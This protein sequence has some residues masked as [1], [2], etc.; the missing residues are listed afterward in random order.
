MPS[1][2]TPSRSSRKIVTTRRISSSAGFSAAAP[3]PCQAARRAL[4]DLDFL[5][6][7]VRHGQD[8]GVEAAQERA[9]QLVDALIAVIRRGDHV[10][11]L[12]RLHLGIQ[13][14][15][16]QR[17]LGKDRDERVLNV[18]GNARQLLDAGDLAVLHRAHQRAERPA[19]QPMGPWPA[20]ARSSSRSGSPPRRCRQCPAPAAW[21][22]RRSPPTRCSLNQ[23][24]AVPG[25][26]RAAERG[27]WR[28][29][30]RRSRSAARCRCTW[31]K[32]RSHCR[33]CHRG[34]KSNGPGREIPIGR[35]LAVVNFRQLGSS[36]AN[37]CRR[38]G[39]GRIQRRPGSWSS[40]G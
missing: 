15:D 30:R 10:E 32:P 16:R 35:L 3:A 28:A 18:G 14:G 37:W 6:H 1:A 9:G 24:F 17:L 40:Q 26:P 21:T 2:V 7:A 38:A 33:A 19:R 5:V 12:A 8:D 23:V 27:R 34:G 31:V 11:A 39:G 25:T 13:L 36:S 29:S 22:H 20:A 4:D